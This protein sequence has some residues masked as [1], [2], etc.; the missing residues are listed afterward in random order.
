MAW[1]RHS[2]LPLIENSGQALSWR[3]SGPSLGWA[4]GAATMGAVWERGECFEGP[5][6]QVVVGGTRTQWLAGW[7][8]EWLESLS[9]RV[10][11]GLG[12]FLPQGGR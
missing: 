6:V 8:M 1:L 7:G 5:T 10:C 12:M 9:R 4:E 2:G 3:G 11:Q